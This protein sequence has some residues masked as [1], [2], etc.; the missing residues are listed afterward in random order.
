MVPFGWYVEITDIELMRFSLMV[1]KYATVVF[2]Q[3][4]RYLH[5][6]YGVRRTGRNEY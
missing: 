5:D 6:Q 1:I 3:E 4:K 2:Y